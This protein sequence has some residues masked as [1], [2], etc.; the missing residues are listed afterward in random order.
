MQDFR[1][2]YSGQWQTSPGLP[3]RNPRQKWRAY[4]YSVGMRLY[5]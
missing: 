5:A 3:S 2:A 4:D 1:A